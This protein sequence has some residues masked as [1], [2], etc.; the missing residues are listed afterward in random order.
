MIVLCF[1]YIFIL[2]VI[3][4]IWALTLFCHQ[5][6]YLLLLLH[7]WSC[8]ENVMSLLKEI[9]FQKKI[10]LSLWFWIIQAFL[11]SPYLLIVC[12][13]SHWKIDVPNYRGTR[14]CENNRAGLE[15]GKT[16]TP[17]RFRILKYKEI[18]LSANP[19]EAHYAVC[20][21]Q[22]HKYR[23][24]H[25]QGISFTSLSLSRGV[26]SGLGISLEIN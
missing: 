26:N 13:A 9:P 22:K 14:L 18:L 16:R 10:R 19:M 12:A 5:R 3:L 11:E 8:I 23:C 15:G 20:I 21:I 17:L 4:L 1:I 2:L 7:Q 25:V 6:K 24:W